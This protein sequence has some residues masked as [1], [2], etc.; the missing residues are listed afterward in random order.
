MGIV[1]DGAK[2]LRFLYFRVDDIA[3]MAAEV[4]A[5]GGQAI[6]VDWPMRRM[7]YSLTSLTGRRTSS[8]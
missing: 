8:A 3:A 2:D 4:R 6:V 5:H 1:A 7:S